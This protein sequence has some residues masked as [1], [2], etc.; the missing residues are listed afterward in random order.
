MHPASNSLRGK[1]PLLIFIL[2]GGGGG[3][4]IS[5]FFAKVL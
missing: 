3:A 1:Q 5:F 2:V 4:V